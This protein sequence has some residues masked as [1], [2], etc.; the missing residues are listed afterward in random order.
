VRLRWLGWPLVALGACS[1]TTGA[2]GRDAGVAVAGAPAA[3]DSVPAR[4][5]SGSDATAD[6]ASDGGTGT[7]VDAPFGDGIPAIIEA[8]IPPS[9]DTLVHDSC[10]TRT[11]DGWCWVSPRP[12]GLTISDASSPRANELWAVGGRG[13]V[14]HGSAG[15]WELVDP[16]VTSD[17]YAVATTERGAVWIGTSDGQVVRRD[18]GGWTKLP[19]PGLPQV[20]AIWATDGDEAWAVGGQPAAYHWTAAAGKWVAVDLGLDGLQA[21]TGSAGNDIWLATAIGR[22]AH[23]DGRQWT[24]GDIALQQRSPYS[25]EQKHDLSF[26]RMGVLDDGTV[27]ASA[28]DSLWGTARYYRAGDG[29]LSPG[30]DSYTVAGAGLWDYWSSSGWGSVVHTSTTGPDEASRFFVGV[31]AMLA[32]R[33]GDV[34]AISSDGG[35]AHIIDD[36]RH[37]EPVLFTALWRLWV[38]SAD[39]VWV[40][41]EGATATSQVAHWDGSSWST[42]AL[43]G[44]HGEPAIAGNAEGQVWFADDILWRWTGSSLQEFPYPAALVGSYWRAT[45]L[46]VNP[47]GLVWVLGPGA[48]LRFDHGTW[49]KVDLPPQFTFYSNENGFRSSGDQDLWLTARN[50]IFHFDGD[51]WSSP[52]VLAA[53]LRDI[54]PFAP[55]DVWAGSFHFDGNLWNDTSPSD[56]FGEIYST[57]ADGGDDVWMMTS[58]GLRRWDGGRWSGPLSFP[59]QSTSWI[60]GSSSHDLWISG[61]NGLIHG[62]PTRPGP[63]LP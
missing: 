29:W 52:T 45:N 9:A 25:W 21:I 62:A 12:Q 53:S 59:L 5:E 42:F 47:G 6:A 24:Q 54:W 41:G 60:A 49:S 31:G 15:R 57:W 18:A 10:A 50:M 37:N 4:S 56:N 58:T 51:R 44:K 39:D 33:A 23:W 14:L 11:A 3:T 16:G 40:S 27:W 63:S 17:L 28:R 38:A 43:G 34:W 20:T 26:T 55:N 36:I 48:L 30:G 7:E 13:T 8:E 32:G 46:V 22:F 1:V 35:M 19:R 61:W 2:A